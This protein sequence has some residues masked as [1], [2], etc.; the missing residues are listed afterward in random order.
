[1]TDPPLPKWTDPAAAA[2]VL[3]AEPSGLGPVAAAL[4]D[5]EGEP[6]YL[7]CETTGLDP[8]RDRVRLLAVSVPAAAGGRVSYLVDCFAVDPAALWEPLAV[9]AVV[10]HNLGFDLA[11]LGRLGFSPGRVRDTL[12]LSQV[13]YAAGYT[14]G[15]P[16]I[17]HGLKDCAARELGV[18]LDKD[19]QA[20]DWAGR[21]SAAQ[22]AYAVADVRVLEPLHAAL[23]G[24]LA[25]AGL[26]RA[27]DV[28]S[29][30]LPAIVWTG[31]AGVPFDRLRWAGLAARAKEDA[32][33]ARAALD[34]AAPADPG[35]LFGGGFHWDSPD[36][37]RRAF[38]LAG[39]EIDSTRDN[40]LAALGHPLA[41]RLRD[42]RDA[43][44]RETTYGLDWLKHVAPDGRVYPHWVPLGA[45]S[46]R[47]ACSKPNMQ[48]LPQ[49]EYRRCVAAPPGRVLVKADYS[50][51]ELRIAAKVSGDRALLDAYRRGEDLHTLTAR[52]V[53]G[54][55]TVTKA[56]R[57]LA[58]AI[59]FGLLYG[60][61]ARG[62]RDYAR[63]HYGLDLTEE[64]AAGYRAA[65]FR[66][67]PGLKRWHQSVGDGPCDTRTLTGRRVLG[68]GRFNEKLNLPV[69]GTGAD[70]LK[71]ALGLLWE[72]RAEC[73]DAVPVLAVHDEIVVECDAGAGPAAAGWLQ[74]CMTD[75][76]APLI[77][78]VPVGVEV[79]TG[80]TWGGD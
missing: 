16:P 73:P 47:M 63:S 57:Q 42:Y 28:E 69:Q 46:G 67:Y 40:V 55:E 62:F 35:R 60:M 74:R 33:R 25:E 77:D 24:K 43:R 54:I 7:D 45:N 6:V 51:V 48:N 23:T 59:N 2:P 34:A 78:P 49:G 68:V 61:G 14:K 30:A 36:D 20:S 52:Q 32:D 50:Q 19:L 56:D 37:V 17:R 22:L 44:K 8:R 58:K 53:L 11:F 4:S 65:F 9:C 12:L 15:V 27:A 5:A 79:H 3:V 13:L 71:V 76:L 64:Q 21:L 70:G 66:A 39:V 41:A 80:P 10:G 38:G 1:V 18:A 26:G 31:A 29:R 72:R 75:A